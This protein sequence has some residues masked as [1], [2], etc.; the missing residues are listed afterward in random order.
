MLK[1]TQNEFLQSVVK[2]TQSDEA[3]VG[4]SRKPP[5][6]GSSMSVHSVVCRLE[7]EHQLPLEEGAGRQQL[8]IWGRRRV[9]GHKL[10]KKENHL[11]CSGKVQRCVNSRCA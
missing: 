2:E 1:Q 9:G 6:K 3:F 11:S 5:D 7:E 8:E 10:H 4:N